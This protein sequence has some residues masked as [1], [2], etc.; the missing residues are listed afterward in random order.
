M[1]EALTEKRCLSMLKCP[2]QALEYYGDAGIGGGE[3]NDSGFF[4]TH[5]E[6]PRREFGAGE[7]TKNGY[8]KALCASWA[9]SFF[10]VDKALEYGEEVA[11]HHREARRIVSSDSKLRK[12][13]RRMAME[14]ADC[15][16]AATATK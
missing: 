11:S 4:A 16:R 12:E 5:N 9:E 2:R 6:L 3:Q 8:P 15:L 1:H 13:C 14:L 7:A 10:Y